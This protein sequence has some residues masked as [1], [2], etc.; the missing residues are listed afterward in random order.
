[1]NLIGNAIKFTPTRAGLTSQ[2]QE[3]AKE[4]FRFLCP[5][6]VR[7]YRRTKRTRFLKSFIRSP[8]L[9]DKAKGHGPWARNFQSP[10]GIARRKDLGGI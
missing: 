3:M 9:E 5:I 7:E 10:G 6:P 1:M 2:L 4:A 8:R